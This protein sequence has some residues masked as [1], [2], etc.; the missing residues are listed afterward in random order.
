MTSCYGIGNRRTDG[1]R[2]ASS[3][4]VSLR[5]L[6]AT[7]AIA[8]LSACNSAETSVSAPTTPTA[9]RCAI[10]ASGSATSFTATGGSGTVSIST[11]RDCTW[12]V[13]TDAG[14]V[15]LNGA[16]TGQGNG[17]VAYAVAANPVPSARAGAI[18]V[19]TQ[20]IQL[21]QAGAPCRFSLSRSADTIGFAGGRMSVDVSTLTGCS[22]SATVP[23]SWITIVSGQS[24]HA[25]DTVVL[26][27]AANTGARRVADV[28]V[29]GQ[30]YTITQTA[31]PAPT[32]PPPPPPVDLQVEGTV[33][34]LS[35]RCPDISFAIGATQVV[36]S[37]STTYQNGNCGDV[38]NGRDVKV[39]G[40]QSKGVVK[41]SRIQLEN[42]P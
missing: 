39:D 38:R 41:A 9:N 1:E 8:A 14:W 2:R 3:R 7:A 11:T 21:N 23:V 33:S 22:W 16:R 29:A 10:Q 27:V 18:A 25:S 4:A 12:T 37:G 17:S 28:N 13:T 34:A 36:A 24:G 15:S 20:T 6:L 42:N 40:T 19:G 31:A 26:S 35:G 30:T 32:P 5:A